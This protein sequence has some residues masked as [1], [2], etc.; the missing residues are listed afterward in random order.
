MLTPLPVR[1]AQSGWAFYLLR[2]LMMENFYVKPFISY[3]TQIELLRQRGL[4]FDDEA[5]A[6]HLLKTI[7]Y[8]RFSG[9]W[10]PFLTDKQQVVFKPDATFDAAFNLYKFDMELRKLILR[11]LEKIEIAVRTQMSYSLSMAH[12]PFWMEDETLFVNPVKYRATLDKINM[13]LKRSDED[14]IIAFAAKYSNPLPPSFMT[15]EIASFGILSKLYGNLKSGLLR[16]EIAQA[17]G[18]TDNLFASWLHGLT[19]IRNICAH[20]ARL[21]NRLLQIQPLFPRRVKHKWISTEGLSNRHVY[22][23]MSMIIYFLNTINPGHTFIQKIDSLLK[24]YPN[25][26]VRAMG[27]PSDWRSESLWCEK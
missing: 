12:G 19:Y 16:R 5:K 24:K 17:F 13:E 10:Y 7:G 25:V 9:Y 23:I 6:L 8:Y 4:K 26:D 1:T 21:W 14:F 20:H 15:L 18:L 22:Y 3:Q 27:F 2:N 11:E